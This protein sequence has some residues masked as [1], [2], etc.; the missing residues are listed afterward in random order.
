[1]KKYI[2]GFLTA[3]ALTVTTVVISGCPAAAIPYLGYAVT[4]APTAY[5]ALP[6]NIEVE[7][8]TDNPYTPAGRNAKIRS[9][10]VADKVVYAHMVNAGLFPN[11]MFVKANPLT[12][13]EAGDLARNNSTD[14]FFDIRYGNPTGNAL[15]STYGHVEVKMI[16]VDG[17]VAYKQTAKVTKKTG[18]FDSQ[19][20]RLDVEQY[21]SV[22]IINDIKSK[23]GSPQASL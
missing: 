1:M 14:A 22:A 3:I 8:G 6:K 15:K 20:S 19:P 11:V 10:T 17:E 5:M 23:A 9:I 12:N 4:V 21:L 13:K 18:L 16:L 7:M 2:S